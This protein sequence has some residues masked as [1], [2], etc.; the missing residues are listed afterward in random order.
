MSEVIDVRED[1][2][3]LLDN[4][5][6]GKESYLEKEYSTPKLKSHKKNKNLIIGVI[7]TFGIVIFLP[8]IFRK[9]NTTVKENKLIID[10]KTGYVL[11]KGEPRIDKYGIDLNVNILKGLYSMGFDG[12][13]HKKIE[14]WTLYTPPCP[15]LR[16]INHADA[17]INPQCE[18]SS[19]QFLD[20]KNYK[21]PVSLKLN[22]ISSQMKKF[23][24]WKKSNKETPYYAEKGFNELLNED[25]HPFDYGYEGEDTKDTDDVAYY[26]DLINSR[27]DEVPDPRRRRLF[28]FILFNSEFDLLDVYLSEFY[29][30]IDYFVIYESNS[31]F[32]GQSKPLYFTRTL[33]ET[34]RYDKY[35]DKLIPL[36]MEIIVNEN[37]GRGF[38]M[39][40]E[41]LAR[42]KVIEMGLRSVHARHGDIF[43]HG[44][45]DEMPKAHIISRLKKC[46]GWEHLQMGI[47]GGPKSFKEKNVDSYFVNQKLGATVT[48]SGEYDVDYHSKLSLGLLSW[49]FEYSFNIVEDKNV[50]TVPHPNIVI[51]DARRSLGQLPELKNHLNSKLERRME[52]YDPLLDPNFDPYQGYTYTVQYT[53]KKIGKGFLGERVRFVT[54]N[55]E[56]MKNQTRPLLWG[57]SWHMSSFLPT[58]DL[59]LN[60]IKSYSHHT[61]YADDDEKAKKNIISRIKNH[62]YIFG[63]KKH[64]DDNIPELPTSYSDGYDYNFDY[65]FW[66]EISQNYDKKEEYKK[67]VEIIKHEIPTQ[68]WKNPICYS[69]MLDREYGFEKKLWWQ[70]V[71]KEQWKTVHFDE[72]S[73]DEIKEITPK[74]ISKS[75]KS[76]MLKNA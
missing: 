54:S 75:F 32:S 66:K 50:G 44:D 40:R 6:G 74:I 52:N 28:S 37:N 70:V 53:D 30:I 56:L 16:P 55:F 41:H 65:S 24:K 17:V 9:N 22:D 39:P 5:D 18:S 35:K 21:V 63:K 57:G 68:V 4:V 12:N 2:E 3:L 47:G 23:K 34:D 60:K 29:E 64:Y 19:L 11:T 58:I 69:Y 49:S 38:A 20:Y 46:G 14:D 45:L 73:S 48:N 76:Q 31:T 13:P 25:Y 10:D 43:M 1:E 15:N 26:S 33:L 62:Q 59:F 61:S 36:P 7:A 27:M 71:P 67:Q 42:R 8:F 72:L 51:F